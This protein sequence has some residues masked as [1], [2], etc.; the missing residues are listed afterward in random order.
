MMKTLTKNEEDFRLLTL[1]TTLINTISF[2]DVN[3]RPDYYSV[4]TTIQRGTPPVCSI[5]KPFA[6]TWTHS[7]SM[8]KSLLL[9][10]L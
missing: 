5:P 8:K 1:P 7:F 10:I 4:P 3:M 2:D 9:K 6:R